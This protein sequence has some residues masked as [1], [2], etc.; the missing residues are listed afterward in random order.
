MD[1][2]ALKIG[3]YLFACIMLVGVE[4]PDD[5]PVELGVCYYLFVLFNLGI[6][7]LLANKLIDKSKKDGTKPH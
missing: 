6:A 5:C 3:I 4:V 7:V 1:M 2:K